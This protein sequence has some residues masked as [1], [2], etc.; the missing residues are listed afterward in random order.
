MWRRFKNQRKRQNE[1][2]GVLNLLKLSLENPVFGE[3]LYKHWSPMWTRLAPFIEKGGR[4]I[5][6]FRRCEVLDAGLYPE[7]WNS[8]AYSNSAPPPTIEQHF[9]FT[10]LRFGWRGNIRETLDGIAAMRRFVDT[11]KNLRAQVWWEREYR[12]FIDFCF[13]FNVS[14]KQ[15]QAFYQLG[16]MRGETMYSPNRQH[17][18]VSVGV[19]CIDLDLRA[20]EKIRSL[21]VALYAI[22]KLCGVQSVTDEEH[23]T[24]IFVRP[25]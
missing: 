6:L 10:S 19:Y 23:R 16:P 14:S 13:W 3:P 22:A 2:C 12:D 11:L 24:H 8:D 25:K 4:T 9:N 7:A 1:K 15:N 17:Y 20:M 5:G 21:D 18:G